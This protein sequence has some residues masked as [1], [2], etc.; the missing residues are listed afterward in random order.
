M[1]GKHLVRE[2][3]GRWVAVASKASA[4]ATAMHGS[5]RTGVAH[6]IAEIDQDGNVSADTVRPGSRNIASNQV[7]RSTSRGK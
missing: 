6:E 5:T 3:N 7:F 4:L 2:K 1:S